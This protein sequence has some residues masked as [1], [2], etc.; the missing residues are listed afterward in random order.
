MQ[1]SYSFAKQ[2]VPYGHLPLSPVQN[3]FTVKSVLIVQI[4]GVSSHLTCWCIS[5]LVHMETW[6]L[7]DNSFRLLLARS[8]SSQSWIWSLLEL[9]SH[10]HPA[11]IFWF[12]HT[13][14]LHP[15]ERGSQLMASKPEQP[16]PRSFTLFTA[17]KTTA[18]LSCRVWNPK[19]ETIW[20]HCFVSELEGHFHYLRHNC[21]VLIRSTQTGPDLQQWLAQCGCHSRSWKCYMQQDTA[22]GLT[23]KC[24]F[25]KGTANL[26]N[27]IIQKK[28]RCGLSF[29][30]NQAKQTN[31]LLCAP[32]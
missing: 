19:M 22:C 5:G 27:R 3:A 10:V 25:Q 1:V 30:H 8:L 18:C 23:G 26:F 24:L 16:D 12:C 17:K 2:Q 28:E 29:R 31:F 20:Q 13:G 9:V 15:Q 14:S 11:R 7:H 4:S 21:S 32:D 6:F